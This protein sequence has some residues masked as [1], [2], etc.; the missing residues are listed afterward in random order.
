MKPG[1][2]KLGEAWK[3]PC[4]REGSREAEGLAQVSQLGRSRAGTQ[5]WP[6][7]QP[8]AFP[9]SS[10]NARAEVAPFCALLGRCPGYLWVMGVGAYRGRAFPGSPTPAHHPGLGA[11]KATRNLRLATSPV[12]RDTVPTVCQAQSQTPSRHWGHSS[13]QSGLDPAL[14]LPQVRETDNKGYK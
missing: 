2:R 1:P 9:S 8:G 10:G 3:P 12:N 13:E 7:L 6:R 5:T 14:A 4:P 11:T